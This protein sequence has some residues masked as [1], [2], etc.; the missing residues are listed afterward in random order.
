[1]KDWAAELSNNPAQDGNT[2][3]QDITQAAD[4]GNSID[5]T[6]EIAD[7]PK[8]NNTRYNPTS[9]RRAEFFKSEPYKDSPAS[10]GAAAASG[11][12]EDLDSKIAFFAKQRFP[13][14]PK[15][16]AIKRY[17]VLNGEIVF[18]DDDNRVQQEIAG[19]PATAGE[20]LGE[21]APPI[22]GATVGAM[23][24]GP[25]GAALGG[26]GGLGWRKVIGN[27]IGD[28]QTAT[29]NALDLSMEALLNYGGAK[30][31]EVFADKFVNRRVS[32]DAVK[33]DKDLTSAIIEK[34]RQL[35]IDVTP[36][37]A[38][39]LSSLINQ[40]TRLGKGFDDAGDIIGEFYKK[41]ATQEGVAIDRFIGESPAGAV[42]GREL[43]NITSEVIQAAKD[44]RSAVA[45]P[46][47]DEFVNSTTLD[48]RTVGRLKRD[49]A[50]MREAKRVIDDPI[51]GLSDVKVKDPVYGTATDNMGSMRIWDAVKKRLDGKA[52]TEKDPYLAARYSSLARNLTGIIDELHPG[53]ANA[54]AAFARMSPEVNA[55]VEGLEGTLSRGKDST[56]SRSVRSL[57]TSQDTAP[58][59]IARIRKHF[60][61]RGKTKEWDETLNYWLRHQ[62]ETVRKGK[63]DPFGINAAG[64]WK[65]KVFGS[66][67]QQKMMRVAMGKERYDA[68][69]DLMEVLEATSRVPKAQSMTQPATEAAKQEAIDAA[70]IASMTKGFGFGAV[71]DWWIANRTDAWR[72]NLAKVITNQESVDTLKQLRQLRS[73]SPTN[74]KSI[75]IVGLALSQAGLYGGDAVISTPYAQVPQVL[76]Q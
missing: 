57:F 16:E 64:D 20:F 49:P 60:L 39:G 1:M 37:E 53:Y 44:A 56:L 58:S 31:G 62:W 26:A 54:R 23:V 18:V 5:W 9:P 33:F 4:G 2:G 52:A 8:T 63:G 7:R 30:L 69:T 15:N 71:R 73:I 70:P 32:R 14:M 67:R 48:P 43:R 50:L 12:I 24:G 35:G 36:A 46:I 28:Q 51:Y 47:Y 40:Q 21:T 10:F 55:Y 66:E 19:A 29:G 45:T 13:D 74:E 38:S 75:E 76:N 41:R 61:D 34:G 59:D 11:T 3:A 68:F 25:P 17:G 27:Y 65:K 6:A 22:V 42:V 72:T